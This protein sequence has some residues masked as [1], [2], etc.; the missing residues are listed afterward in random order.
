MRVSRTGYA[1]WC[2]GSICDRDKRRQL[3]TAKVLET[4]ED[5]EAGCRFWPIP[6]TH[7]GFNRSSFLELFDH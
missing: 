7:S 1:N 3:M 5:F 2:K 6:I 4:Y